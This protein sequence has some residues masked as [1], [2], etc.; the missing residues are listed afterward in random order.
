MSLTDRA[1]TDR[2]FSCNGRPGRG[3]R[4]EIRAREAYHVAVD[5]S[6]VF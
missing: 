5:E 4:M 3:N 1:G 2:G 6:G